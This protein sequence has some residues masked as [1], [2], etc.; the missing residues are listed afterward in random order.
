MMKDDNRKLWV[1]AVAGLAGG[2]AAAWAVRRSLRELFGRG[3]QEE[4]P[5]PEEDGSEVQTPH[6][7][8][9][10]GSSYDDSYSGFRS[11]GER[12]ASAATE[13]QATTFRRFQSR[14]ERIGEAAEKPKAA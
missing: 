9:M 3:K 13:P 2:L 6:V 11:R 7:A 4:I 12:I 5:H 14:G 8:E 10:P 1:A